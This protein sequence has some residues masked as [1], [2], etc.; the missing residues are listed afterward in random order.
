M[1]TGCKNTPACS[2][3]AMGAVCHGPSLE[4]QFWGTL[5]MQE[6]KLQDWKMQHQIAMVEN[7]GLENAAQNCKGGNCRTGQCDTKSHWWKVQD[8][9]DIALVNYV[10]TTHIFDHARLRHGTADTAR[11]RPTPET[12]MSDTK[13]EVENGSGNNF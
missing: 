8:W 11:H 10:C 1:S 12:Q 4:W 9:S 7:A 13:P 5:K 6:R 3:V 2:S